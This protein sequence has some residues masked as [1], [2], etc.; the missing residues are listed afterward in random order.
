MS[1]VCNF[2]NVIDILSGACINLMSVIK[3]GSSLFPPCI[4]SGGCL[5]VLT[6]CNPCNPLL[7]IC[8]NTG[9]TD[10]LNVLFLPLTILMTFISSVSMPYIAV[11]GTALTP[12]L[13][14]MGYADIGAALI[15]CVQNPIPAISGSL[16]S[17]V[18][19]A[20]I[21]DILGSLGSVCSGCLGWCGS[22]LIGCCQ[23]SG[24]LDCILN[25]LSGYIPMRIGFA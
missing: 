24:L 16:K 23:I 3:I 25:T 20:G 22:K 13:T 2:A 8:V 1:G 5:N 19:S 18:Y 7:P 17:F 9:L 11:W 14:G 15:S 10:C 12:V 21:M 4:A 6:G